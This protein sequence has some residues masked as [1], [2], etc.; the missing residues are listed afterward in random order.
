M[1]TA[2]EEYDC[3]DAEEFGWRDFNYGPRWRSAIEGS[4][5]ADYEGHYPQAV[6]LA[7]RFRKH[8]RLPRGRSLLF[9]GTSTPDAILSAR[10]LKGGI[11]GVSFTRE[12][13]IACHYAMLGQFP[14]VSSAIL[15][16]DRDEMRRRGIVIEPYDEGHFEE[17]RADGSGL[18]E[19]LAPYDLLP[20]RGILVSVHTIDPSKAAP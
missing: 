14:E 13:H 9:H 4:P 12:L 18:A 19:E 11:G 5:L 8:V 10:H 20:L 3:D 7:A 16:F 6:R 15:V 2:F 17:I 1:S